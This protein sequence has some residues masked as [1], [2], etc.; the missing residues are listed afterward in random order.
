MADGKPRLRAALYRPAPEKPMRLVRNFCAASALL[1]CACA[2]THSPAPPPPAATATP[3]ASTAP[4]PKVE[5]KKETPAALP[6]AEPESVGPHAFW[7]LGPFPVAT[8]A[9]QKA[10]PG[11]D[12]D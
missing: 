12:K 3:V 6:F 5:P 8:S 4:T 7:V 2:A 11:M 9:D 10:H 1:T